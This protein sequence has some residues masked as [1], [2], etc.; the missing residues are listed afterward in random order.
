MENPEKFAK[1]LQQINEFSKV[2]GYKIN[3]QKSGVF[4]DAWVAQSVK[5]LPS[6]QVMIPGTWDRALCWVP[7]P[8]PLCS[9]L[10]ALFLK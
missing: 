5:C 2:K 1:K 10:L 8:T 4:R 6:A 9:F 3:A 7:L